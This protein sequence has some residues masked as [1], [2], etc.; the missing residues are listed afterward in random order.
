MPMTETSFAPD[1]EGGLAVIRRRWP[2]LVNTSTEAPVFVLAAG[3]RSGSTLLQ[4]LLMPACFI[5][6]EPFG[7]ADLI[8]S[9][10]DHLRCFTHRCP[11]ELLTTRCFGSHWRE[12]VESILAGHQKVDGLVVRFEDLVQGDFAS[13]EKYLGFPLSQE[14]F[15]INPSDGGPPALTSIPEPERLEL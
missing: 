3:W 4:R 14:A 13:I 6:G 9:L 1:L 15:Q 10:A 11:D 12:L 5:W 7:H 2:E 8:D